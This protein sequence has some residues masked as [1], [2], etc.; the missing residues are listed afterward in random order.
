MKITP[1]DIRHK[2]FKRSM[3][4]YSEE[5]VDIFLDE[6]ADDFEVLFK[7]NIELQDEIHRLREKVAQYD[8]IKETLQKTLIGAQQQA[9]A[10]QVNARKESELILK[11]A[12]IKARGIVAESYAEKQKVQQSITQLRQLEDDFRF[13]FKSL[14]EAHLNLLMEDEGSEDRRKARMAAAAEVRPAPEAAVAEDTAPHPGPSL[15]ESVE[16]MP[17]AVPTSPLV[18][19]E[20]EPE[21]EP[22]AASPVA[23]AVPVAPVAAAE[24]V[25]EPEPEVEPWFASEA[26]P[27]KKSP[28]QN[29]R[30]MVLG[31]TDAY[32]SSAPETSR[33]QA[34]EV[35]DLDFGLDLDQP[36]SAVGPVAGD[37][38]EDPDPKG[39]KESS[40]RRFF[41]GS[42]GEDRGPGERK[43]RDDRDF[44]W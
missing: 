12:E 20:P 32:M 40:V 17:P 33:R 36:L 14:L 15:E 41:F 3:R 1:I 43:D 27:V 16:Q 18:I 19:P 9:D 28:P 29:A 4:G 39:R 10:M 21:P 31:P 5:E 38:D 7:E 2:E 35:D 25:S 22:V 23:A 30:T 8:T 44:D 11:D 34:Q 13:K 42:K 24:Q 26:A 37:A 6:V